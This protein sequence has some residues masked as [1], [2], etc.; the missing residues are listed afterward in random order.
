[1]NILTTISKAIILCG[2]LFCA[3][4]AVNGQ[5]TNRLVK[6]LSNGDEVYLKYYK[7]IEYRSRP[8]LENADVP[9]GEVFES[10]KWTIRKFILT[11]K[12][13]QSGREEVLWKY[14]NSLAIKHDLIFSG[15]DMDDVI[16]D[17]KSGY[18]LYTAFNT[19]FVTKLTRDE[20]GWYDESSIKLATSYEFKPIL[21][22]K[23]SVGKPEIVAEYYAGNSEKGLWTWKLKGDKWILKSDKLIKNKPRN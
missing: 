18:V 15:F 9:E 23:F 10:E 4:F 12:N 2:F 22:A 6:K 16:L 3:V 13:P 21:E 7:I 8:K 11:L 20:N 1:M 19:L 14:S 5:A 17:E